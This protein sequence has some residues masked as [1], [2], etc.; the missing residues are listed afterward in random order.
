MM[1]L[2]T[3]SDG[4]RMRGIRE[5]GERGIRGIRGKREEVH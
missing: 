5:L 3:E 2:K 4:W 1:N